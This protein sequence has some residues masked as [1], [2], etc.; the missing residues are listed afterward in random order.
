MDQQRE[1]EFLLHIGA[2]TDPLTALATLPRERK[3]D[4]TPEAAKPT[5]SGELDL[6]SWVVLVAFA[7]FLAWL[8]AL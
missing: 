5:A 8:V 7:M 2:G 3:A 4:P 1:E 6:L